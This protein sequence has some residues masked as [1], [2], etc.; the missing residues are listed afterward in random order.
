MRAATRQSSSLLALT[1]TV[2]VTL[3][4]A[5]QVKFGLVAFPTK[6]ALPQL[7]VDGAPR[8]DL[9]LLNPGAPFFTASFDVQQGSKYKYSVDG[10]QEAFDREV[11]VRII[12]EKRT[13]NDFYGRAIT[14]QKLPNLPWPMG[15]QWTRGVHL[16]PMFD[17]SYVPTIHLQGDV[18]VINNM[19]TTMNGSIP[20][21]MTVI[22][23]DHVLTF[24]NVS[25]AISAAG[26]KRNYAKQAYKLKLQPRD[27]LFGRDEWKLRNTEEDPTQLREKIYG[28]LLNAAGCPVIQANN[29]RLYVNMSPVGS[30]VMDDNADQKSFIRAMFHG[31][32]ESALPKDAP[33]G[34]LL[35]GDSLDFQYLGDDPAAYNTLTVAEP[36]S[37]PASNP[38]QSLIALIK[39]L[40]QTGTDDASID[41]FGAKFD[42][43]TFLRAMA[44]EYLNVHWD[45]YWEMGTNFVLYEDP[46][47]KKWFFI[48]QDFD[49]TMG[50]ATSA[51]Y[52][53]N[54]TTLSYK[55]YG[56]NNKGQ[57]RPLLQKILAAP[58]YAARFETILKNIVTTLYN[59]ANLGERIKAAH[60]RIREDVEWDR[61][62]KRRHTGRPD[63]WVFADFDTNLNG[64]VKFAEWGFTQ[65]IDERSK[66]VASEFQVQLP[67]AALT[68]PDPITT[69]PGANPTA[70]INDINKYNHF[71]SAGTL[72]SSTALVALI[73][74]ASILIT[75]L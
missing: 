9:Q 54:A 16:T 65:W 10:V 33:I 41:A 4:E 5:V 26:R 45:G 66:A 25:Y 37:N 19:W 74:F 27:H 6:G 57:P 47:T 43:E 61:Q 14:V 17:D 46:I 2:L 34:T 69:V 53:R 35:Q 52:G 60:A 1:F 59:P 38:K 36:G 20:V 3:T 73:G 15:D 32:K 30:Y 67:T 22:T 44:F 48:D 70:S 23:A 13:K 40:N 28:Q 71:S 11:D 62:Q 18:G 75:H 58:K 72:T 64:P 7:V 12:S 50:V 39:Y 8:G 56:G 68:A 55:Q 51:A 49:M 63:N 31:Q 21:T 24:R 29:I 42:I